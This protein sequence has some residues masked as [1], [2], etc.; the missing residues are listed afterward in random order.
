MEMTIEEKEELEEF[1]DNPFYRKILT[2]APDEACWDYIAYGLVHG[3]YSGFDPQICRESLEESLTVDD[4]KYVRKNL[5][6]NNPFLFKC[7]AR[8]QE[9]N[10]D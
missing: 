9:E 1:L 4:W 2:N 7:K 10:N 8:I 5:A 6:G 3:F